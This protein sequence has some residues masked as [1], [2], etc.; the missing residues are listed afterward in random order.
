[1]T[2]DVHSDVAAARRRAGLTQKR[3]GE[4]VGVSRQTVV[5][6]EAGGYNPSTA[7][8]L[9]MAVVLETPVGELFALADGEVADLRARRDDE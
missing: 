4:L 2:A 9:R 7:V 1:M 6:I 8:A 3:L 5:E